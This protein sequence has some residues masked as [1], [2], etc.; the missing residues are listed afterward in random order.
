MGCGGASGDGTGALSGFIGASTG[1]RPPGIICEVSC[2][3]LTGIFSTFTAW[4]SAGG[5]DG[6]GAGGAGA[7]AGGTGAGWGAGMPAAGGATSLTS[8]GAPGAAVVVMGSIF[9]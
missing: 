5:V 2:W 1:F 9:V 6:A 8:R 3:V 4:L 7:E